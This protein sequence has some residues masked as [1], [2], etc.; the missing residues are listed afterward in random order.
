MSGEDE[1][2]VHGFG[3]VARDVPAITVAELRFGFRSPPPARRPRVRGNPLPVPFDMPNLGS[4]WTPGSVVLREARG[5]PDLWAHGDKGGYLD[6]R[7]R[8]DRLCLSR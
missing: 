4:K 8:R 7:G 2:S 5:M 6:G 3:A 1:N